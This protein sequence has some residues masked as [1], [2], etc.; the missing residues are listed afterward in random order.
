ML[1]KFLLFE[2]KFT[3]TKAAAIVG[4]FA[5]LSKFVALVRD[6]L[7]T[8]KFG[9][10]QIYILDIYNAAFRVPDFIFS[11]FILGTLSVALIPIFVDIMVKDEN[12][13]RDFA[14]TI[15]TLTMLSMGGIFI[16]LY[17]FSWQIT[18]LLVPGFTPEM[19]TETV[20]LTRIIILAQIIFTLSNV[21]T[22][23]LYSYK[24]FII[25][26]IAPILYNLGIILGILVFYPRFG[27]SGLGYG[28][29][30]GAAGHLLIQLPELGRST[31]RL[32]PAWKLHDPA[33]KKFF[34]LYLPR[35]FA[36][37]LPV[38][39]LLISTF[40][41]SRFEAGS[42]GIFTL[43][44]N[45][46]SLP[47]SIIALS[48]ATAIFPALSEAYAKNQEL[49]FLDMLK[50]AFVQILYFMIPLTLL[51][52]IFRA[53]GVRLYLGHGK[54]TWEN[55]ILTFNTFGVLAFSLISQSLA[56]ILSRAFYSRQNT[57]IPVSINLMALALNACLA[58]AFKD[59]YGI[60]GI[61]AAFSVASI[62]NAVTLFV[63]L[64]AVLYKDS[65][66]YEALKKFDD[67]LVL[68][69]VK[70]ILASI[71]MALTCH[72][73]LYLLEPLL[74][75]HT[76]IGLLIQVGCS[77]FLGVVVFFIVST[78]LKLKESQIILDYIKK[79]ISSILPN[80]KIS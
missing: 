7:F 53:Q 25:A 46:L 78:L 39:S 60:I 5:L 71:A 48:L 56:P 27:I 63:V 73:G 34:K 42:I 36:I 10:D 22:N 69:A 51:M 2:Q 8:S 15:I 44:I 52:L 19:L 28:V 29:L 77:A 16:L 33:I 3:I 67:G 72:E 18:K 74:N 65:K 55:T 61:A 12:R 43:S 35:I 23:I 49:I 30:L 58:F 64:R 47:V 6:P 32:L 20:G 80:E 66:N 75:T 4:F 13:A 45:L 26:G 31:F 41:A 79:I 54:F 50:K 62:F 70:I 24:R 40:I 68:T 17:I 59:H 11:I 14:N 38:F 76:V 1:K 57:I 9:G 37:D 21:C